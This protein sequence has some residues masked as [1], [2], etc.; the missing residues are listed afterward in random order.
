LST[1]FHECAWKIGDIHSQAKLHNDKRA[2][3]SILLHLITGI[4]ERLLFPRLNAAKISLLISTFHAIV[5]QCKNKEHGC[6]NFSKENCQ[7][8]LGNKTELGDRNWLETNC[9]ISYYSKDYQ[10]TVTGL[11]DM[12]IW[13]R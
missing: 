11:Q 3:K 5:L 7:G 4:R 2:G 13:I 9:H 6:E 10:V 1:P 12:A 8:E